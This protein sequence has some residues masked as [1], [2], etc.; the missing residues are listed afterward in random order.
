MFAVPLHLAIDVPRDQLYVANGSN[1]LVFHNAS[2][3]TGNVAPNRS[4]TTSADTIF[5]DATNDRLYVGHTTGLVLPVHRVDVFDNAST[6]T[7]TVTADRSITDISLGSL[8]SLF[9]DVGNDRLFV[10]G[11]NAIGAYDSASTSAGTDAATRDRTLTL[12]GALS[13]NLSNDGPGPAGRR[14]LR[15]ARRGHRAGIAL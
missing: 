14:P 12:T 10:L 1:V 7:G 2:T 3:A 4:L 9:V 15:A 13:L 6:R 8:L 5:V 11:S